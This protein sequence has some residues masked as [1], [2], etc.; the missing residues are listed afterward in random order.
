MGLRTLHN[1]HAD[2]LARL[3][4][5]NAM[6]AAGLQARRAVLDSAFSTGIGEALDAF[7]ADARGRI[8][9]AVGI[10]Q[11]A[12]TAMANVARTLARDQRIAPPETTDFA[13]SRFLVE[14]ERLEQRCTRDF[15]GTAS[16]VLHRRKTLGALFFDTIALQVVRV[17]EIA[18]REVRVWMNG[19][20]RP[21]EA[22]VGTLQEQAN[23][24]IEG[25]GR[26]QDAEGDL[27]VRL[28]ELKAIADEV[29]AQRA[30]LEAHAEKLRELVE[31][32]PARG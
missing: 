7:F 29:G 5:P 9:S 26:I 21:L 11:E 2:E 16:L 22:Q 3:L 4:D 24:R 13:T 23:S 6:R 27:L 12:K 25:M 30:E 14:I 31:P 18:D 15:K 17:F 20:V 32:E 28:E 1:R 8:E 10:I 19:F